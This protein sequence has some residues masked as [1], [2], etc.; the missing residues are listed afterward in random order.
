MP[1]DFLQEKWGQT[2][3]CK[4]VGSVLNI[5][6]KTFP[7]HKQKVP[8]RARL[9]GMTLVSEW[10]RCG[11]WMDPCSSAAEEPCDQ[12]SSVSP[13]NGCYP[14]CLAGAGQR[15]HPSL[16]GGSAGAEALTGA[17]LTCCLHG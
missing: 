14:P 15:M 5:F 16:C 11:Q 3:F 17:L 12:V 10:F 7:F 2:T 9:M 6:M 13:G 1:Y 4:V 8:F